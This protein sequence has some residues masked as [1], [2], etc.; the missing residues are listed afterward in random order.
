MTTKN[1]IPFELYNKDGDQHNNIFSNKYT[2]LLIFIIAL[3]FIGYAV[4]VYYYSESDNIIK[5]NSSYYGENILLYEPLFSQQS[6]TIKDCINLCDNDLICDGITYN[7]DTQMCLGTKN[8]HIRNDTQAYSAWVKPKT[9]KNSS[10]STTKKNNFLKSILIGYTNTS[11]K[12]SGEKLAMPYMLGNYCYSFNLTIYDFYKNYGY[13]RHIFH[14]GTEIQEGSVL[15]Y[16][17]WENLVKEMPVQVIGVWLAPFSNNL[18]IAITTTSIGN[19]NSGTYPDAF[20]EKCKNNF[21]NDT[22]NDTGSDNNCYITDLPNGRWADKSKIGDGTTP[23]SK[24]NTYIEYFDNDLQNIPINTQINIIINF[25]NTNAEVYFNGKIVNITQLNG[26]PKYDK[27]NVYVLH[28]K[29]ANC[30]IS[31]LLYYPDAV[32]LAEVN[33]IFTMAPQ[34]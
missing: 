18:R 2:I 19:N 4:Y 12:V 27:S 33:N 3:L 10:N 1:K 8:G 11:R 24:I 20:V 13:W 16:Q 28:D 9:Y 14:K 7:N 32:K 30:E 6:N 17:S 21:S 5:Q 23:K 22:G 29:T 15:T 34:I 26:T 31:N 25:R